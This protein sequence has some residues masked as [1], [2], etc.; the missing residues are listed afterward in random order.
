MGTGKTA[1]GKRLA[2]KIQKEF[3]DLDQ[4]I[5]REAGMPVSDIF[6]RENEAG[7]RMRE[8]KTLT[9][10]LERDDLVVS[11]GGGVVVTP[12]NL[13]DLIRHPHV[14][15]LTATPETLLRRIGNDPRRPLLQSSRAP[16]ERIRE[17]LAARQTLYDRIPHQI[18]TDGLRPP[19]V[20]DRILSELRKASPN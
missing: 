2:E 14:F 1:V 13:E 3:V 15:C 8:R 9:H 19:E 4:E 10:V 5:E 16:I 18:A 20:A 6:A 17:L 11:C 12:E 7:F